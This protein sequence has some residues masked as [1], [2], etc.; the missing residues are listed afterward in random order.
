MYFGKLRI[1]IRSTT[2]IANFV[3]YRLSYENVKHLIT[4][5]HFNTRPCNIDLFRNQAVSLMTATKTVIK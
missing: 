3:L 4:L 5:I 1:N 2:Y